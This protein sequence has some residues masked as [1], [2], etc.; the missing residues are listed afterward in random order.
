[1]TVLATKNT[2]SIGVPLFQIADQLREALDNQEVDLRTGEIIGWEKVDA[3]QLQAMDKVEGVC[4]YIKR[5][6]TLSD[7]MAAAIKS[8]QD[9]KRV[10]EA[11]AKGLRSYVMVNMKAMGVKKIECAQ[12]RVTVVPTQGQLTIT[13]LEDVPAKFITVEM[14]KTPD[15][16]AIKK[17]IKAGEEVPGAMLRAGESLRIA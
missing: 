9:R 6:E 14:V 13:K 8:I 7:E 4:A 17:A 15:K 1:M 3:L 10:L 12:M 16:T 2:P 5:M 11:K